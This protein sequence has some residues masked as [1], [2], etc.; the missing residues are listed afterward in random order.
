MSIRY[1]II[2]PVFN[3]PDELSELL[4]S[5]LHVRLTPV[6]STN[7]DTKQSCP[8]EIIVVEDGSTLRSDTLCSRFESNLPLKYVYQQNQGPGAARNTGAQ[9]ATGDWL[10]FFD[11]DCL[12]PPGYFEHLDTRL[13]TE[14]IDFFGGPDRADTSFSPV[15]RAIDYSMTSFFTTG[16]IRGSHRSV[17][18]YYP[19]TFNMGVRKKAFEQTKGFSGLRFGED[20]DLSMRLMSAGF[21]SALIEEA[22]VYHKRRTDFKKF[23]KQVYNSGMARVVLNRL[24]PGTLKKVHLLP[25]LFVCYLAAALFLTPFAG[26]WVWL[27]VAAGALLLFGDAYRKT[28]HLFASLL[29]PV[30]AFVQLTGYGIGLIHSFFL[31]HLLKRKEASAFK[32]TFYK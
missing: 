22:W 10:L 14:S 32:K 27:P 8:F 24:H 16:G 3:R 31:I 21:R 30:A 28:R 5:L 23:F 12:I 19:R 4:E 13:T 2:I 18:R 15:Q 7:P 29:S 9:H 17:D 11:S 6:A 20:L 26:G 1:S 25:S